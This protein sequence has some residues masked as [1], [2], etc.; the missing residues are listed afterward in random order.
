MLQRTSTKGRMTPLFL[1]G[2]L[3]SFST[4]APG[5]QGEGCFKMANHG[6]MSQIDECSRGRPKPKTHVT[7]PPSEPVTNFIGHCNTKTHGF[8]PP[9]CR[10]HPGP[11]NCPTVQQYPWG[12]VAYSSLLLEFPTTI[13]V[14]ML[15]LSCSLLRGRAGLEGF[16]HFPIMPAR[17]PIPPPYPFMAPRRKV[18]ARGVGGVPFRVMVLRP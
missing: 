4:C 5:T 12:T 3:S 18:T 10:P 17:S 9:L 6:G 16:S 14:V 1:G 11:A 8:P 7:P 15:H 2:S 13:L